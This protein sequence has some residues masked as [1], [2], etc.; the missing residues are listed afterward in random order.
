MKKEKLTSSASPKKRCRFLCKGLIA[1]AGLLIV[2][3]ALLLGRLSMG[4]INLDFI[5]PDVEA[6]LTVPQ[7]QVSTSIAHAQL[8]WREWKRPF[9]IE[10]VDIKIGKAQNPQWLK[11]EHIGASLYLFHLL[12]GD[13]SLKELRL[14]RPH[15][16]LEKDE[17][18]EF[19]LE[20]GESKPDQQPTFKDLA[21]LLV[22]GNPHPSLGKLNDLKKISIVDAN[23]LLKDAQTHQDWKFPK[24]TFV[25]KR[26]SDGF[27]AEL[28]T[29]AQ[30]SFTMGISHHLSSPYVKIYGKFREFAFQDLVHNSSSEKQADNG[31]L[32]FLHQWNLPL[33]GKVHVVLAPETLQLVEGNC[34]LN[35]GKGELN[36]SLAKLLPFPIHSGN[37]SFT[38]TPTVLELSHLSLTSD[39]M[40]C[41]LSGRL[42][43]PTTPLTLS[44]LLNAKNTLDLT[45]KIKDLSLN[46]LGALW[47]QGVAHHARTWLTENLR[48]GTVNQAHFAFKGHG[49]ESGFVVDKLTGT[50]EADKVEIN[51]LDGL[52]PA[53]NVK[54][55]GTFDHKACEL[56]L[57][58]G[59]IEDVKLESG[60]IILS[61]LDTNDEAF[62]IDAKAAGPIANM[63]H[64]INHKPLEYASYGGIDPKKAKGTG[65]I[66]LHITFPLVSDLQF[67]DVKLALKGALKN[68]EVERKITETLKAQLKQGDLSIN[69]TQD[70][71]NIEGQAVLN[72]LPAQLAYSQSFKS[73]DPQELRIDIK[74][75]ASFEDFKRLGFDY[76]EYAQGPTKTT[77]TYTLKRNKKSHFYVELDTTP[78]HLSFAPLG[79]YKEPGAAGHIFF[80]LLFEDGNLSKM[81]NLTMVIPSY[82]LKGDVYFGHQGHWQ[83]IHL[84]EFKGPHTNAQ[85]TLHTPQT[86]VYEISCTGQEVDLEKFL[87][88]VNAEEN[89]VDHSPTNVKLAAQVGQLRLGEGKIFEHINVS[90]ELFLQGQDTTWKAVKL[91]AKAG[92][93]VA[94]SQK[95]DVSN[96]AGGIAFDLIPG[97][98]NTQTLEVRANDAGK[99]LKN[100]SIYDAVKGGYIVIKASRQGKGP[101][102]GSFKLKEFDVN[103]VPILARFGAL[104]SPMG[105][106]NLFSAKETLSMDRFDCDFQFSEDLIVV[107]KGIGKSI[108][109]GFTVDGKLNRQKRMYSLKGNIIPARFIN[110]IFSNIPIIGSLLNGG[111]GEGLFG[112]AYSVTGGF[113]NPNISLNPLSMLAPGFIRKLFQSI[114]EEE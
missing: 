93:H 66:D 50:L 64:I 102:Q 10:L 83:T 84:S 17:K 114:G 41:E 25:L 89:K 61:Q 87:E 20:F 19:N 26:Q 105:I 80:D 95:S 70:K 107:K 67:K 38:L 77:L 94:Q 21:P 8:V 22:L 28:S 110:S 45:G 97:P 51:Y 81:K 65:T 32:N 88:Y 11:I 2:L 86:D 42:A 63:L 112:I 111:E 23:I 34:E 36:L 79:W 48:E 16:L 46:H 18:G 92:K 40:M 6:E 72:Q 37:L 104:L 62:A 69:L 5:L 109:L 73:T 14:Y 4:P 52:P 29:R 30:G 68:V 103:K 3:I 1:L 7:A 44:N 54:T 35:V 27:Q 31:I 53:K 91:R 49:E 90:A 9:E 100:L 108:A 33:T 96:V 82:S 12:T 59:H 74:T 58:A 71:M 39:K 55:R 15:I 113:D 98:N 43:S 57:L 106:A 47:P 76:L 99:L 85:L 24:A 101:Y 60:R 75:N 13:I 56:E 78:A